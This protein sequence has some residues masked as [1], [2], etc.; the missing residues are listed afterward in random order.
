MVP[1]TGRF[2][3]NAMKTTHDKTAKLFVSVPVES[4][5]RIAGRAGGALKRASVRPLTTELKGGN[6]SPLSE[7]EKDLILFE[8]GFEEL[9]GI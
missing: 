7:R 5:S 2:R 3:S 4:P 1:A 6:I 9:V 8:L